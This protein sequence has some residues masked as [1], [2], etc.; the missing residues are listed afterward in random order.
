MH[1]NRI[2]KQN[3]WHSFAALIWFSI[4]VSFIPILSA[5]NSKQIGNDNQAENQMFIERKCWL[6]CLRKTKDFLQ[7]S[8]HKWL[9]SCSVNVWPICTSS[10][11]HNIEFIFTVWLCAYGVQPIVIENDW[12][13]FSILCHPF[14]W[15]L[16]IGLLL[17]DRFLRFFVSNRM[18]TNL[19]WFTCNRMC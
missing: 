3:K 4:I 11:I 13:P 18:R 14:D 7:I 6:L 16:L 12:N 10:K 2:R 5:P 9:T 15:Y 17:G 1:F 8:N 19:I